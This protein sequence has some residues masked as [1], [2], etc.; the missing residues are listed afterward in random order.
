MKNLF[1][2]RVGCAFMS[3]EQNVKKRNLNTK[4]KFLVVASQ[5]VNVG[6]VLIGST[7]DNKSSCYEIMEIVERRPSVNLGRHYVWAKTKW[8]QTV[9]NESEFNVVRNYKFGR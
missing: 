4:T 6:D 9:I 8:S 3:W 5:E 2:D 1:R 7:T